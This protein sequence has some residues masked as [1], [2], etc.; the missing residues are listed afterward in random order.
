MSSGIA[1]ASF[2]DALN[3]N[4]TACP[5][6]QQCSGQAVDSPSSARFT[7]RY[8]SSLHPN[9]KPKL[10]WLAS[11]TGREKNEFV[12]DAMAGYFNELAQVRETLDSRYDELLSGKVKP[13][14]GEEAFQRLIEETEVPRNPRPERLRTSPRSL[15]RPDGIREYIAADNPAAA[16]R[17]IIDIFDAIRALV[18]FPLKGHPRA[19]LTSRRLRFWRVRDYL[20]AYAPDEK[21]L[22]LLA[23]FHTGRSPRVIAAILRERKGVT[24][25]ERPRATAGRTPR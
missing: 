12:L 24:A 11:E 19:D 1:V 25:P 9:W 6:P 7:G 23:V 13:M 17:V 8:G 15:H 2:F 14:D 10:D 5:E 16:R 3:A 22:W 21:P 4:S 20:I 18:P